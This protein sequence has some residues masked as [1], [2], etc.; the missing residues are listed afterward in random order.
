[1]PLVTLLTNLP[2]HKLSAELH[3]ALSSKLSEVLAKP[4]ERLS[5]TIVGGLRMSRGG[6]LAPVCEL[7][8]ASIGF[9]CREKTQP[10]ARALT[11]FL[12]EQTGIPPNRIL[13]N[14]SDLSPYM[15]ASGGTLVG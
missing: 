11:D 1:M 13:M 14:F 12:A 15:I 10:A 5:V 4:E 8:V 9:D 2:D 3:L 7:R 6:S